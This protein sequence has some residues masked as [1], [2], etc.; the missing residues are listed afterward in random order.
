MSLIHNR[1][2]ISKWRLLAID[3]GWEHKLVSIFL[4]HLFYSIK[5][6]ALGSSFIFLYVFMTFRMI[7]SIYGRGEFMSSK[8]QGL[9]LQHLGENWWAH[10]FLGFAFEGGDLIWHHDKTLSCTL[11]CLAK[12]EGRKQLLVSIFYFFL[13]SQSFF[14]ILRWGEQNSPLVPCKLQVFVNL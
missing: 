12:D 1:T 4:S 13:L 2:L 3:E 9:V 6:K 5:F 10:F 11:K 8:I 14:G 7:S